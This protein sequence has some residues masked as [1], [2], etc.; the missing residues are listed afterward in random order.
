LAT[1]SALASPKCM[2]TSDT[3]LH[4]RL[5]C[6]QYCIPFIVAWSET[7]P[8]PLEMPMVRLE[9]LTDR[10]LR[11]SCVHTHAA[12]YKENHDLVRQVREQENEA[13]PSFLSVVLLTLFV[14]TLF[15]FSRPPVR[16]P[17]LPAS[18][19]SHSRLRASR[20]FHVQ[21]PR[22]GIYLLVDEV[23]TATEV[24]YYAH[25]HAQDRT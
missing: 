5:A 14:N 10:L 1:A 20:T 4:R 6:I 21:H 18:L 12:L 7:N 19:I 9:V 22:C 3:L 16:T 13:W 2:C 8:A 15:A 23:G 11:A 24:C 25:R 17:S